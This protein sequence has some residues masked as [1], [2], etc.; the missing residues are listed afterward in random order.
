[1]RRLPPAPLA[2]AP[3]AESTLTLRFAVFDDAPG[4]LR[5]AQLDSAAPLSDPILIADVSGRLT[6][7]LSLADDRV[8]A[9]PFV[10]TMGAVELLRAR[11]RQLS[12]RGRWGRRQQR[13]GRVRG[14]RALRRANAL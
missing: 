4:L 2:P 5:L 1:M 9:D 7:A 6:A 8:L 11:A 13:R 10:L 12:G 14:L 3:D